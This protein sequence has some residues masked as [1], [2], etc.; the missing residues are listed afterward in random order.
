MEM[1][2]E[3]KN[4]MPCIKDLLRKKYLE[5][6]YISLWTGIFRLKNRQRGKGLMYQG[7]KEVF[8]L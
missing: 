6:G 3:F 2:K 5:N 8:L 7:C 1:G 4:K